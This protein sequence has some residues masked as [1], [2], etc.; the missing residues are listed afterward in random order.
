MTTT[1]AIIA[2][3]WFLTRPQAEEEYVDSEAID[4][5]FRQATDLVEESGLNP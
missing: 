5:I 4:E 1:A 3:I 2:G